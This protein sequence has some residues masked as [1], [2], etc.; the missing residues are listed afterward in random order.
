MPDITILLINRV[1]KCWLI[2][3]SCY[4]TISVGVVHAENNLNQGRAIRFAIIYTEEPPYVYSNKMSEY[5]GIIPKVVQALGR[6]LSF[7]VAFFPTS[8]KGLEASIIKGQADFT[9]LAPEWSQ[10]TE[11]LIFSEPVL[12]YREFL[13]SLQPFYLSDKPADWV[14]GKT[15][16]VHENYTY[17]VLTPFFEQQIAEPIEVSSEVLITSIFLGQKC[18]LIYINEL[19][20]NWAFQALSSEIEIYRSS[21]PLK[22]THQTFMFNKSWHR[23]LQKINQ[24]IANIRQSGELKKIVDAQTQ[25]SLIA[26]K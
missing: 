8:R 3:L 26:S 17:P 9:W 24:A 13:Y 7:D 25:F 14:R 6:E 11:R 2:L 21:Q 23:H 18:D 22:Q 20:A 1:F 4:L 19:R 5:N 10:N 16:C 15:I 12:N